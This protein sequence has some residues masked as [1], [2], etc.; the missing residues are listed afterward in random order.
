M[1]AAEITVTAT[2]TKT[3]TATADPTNPKTGD[4]FSLILWS[5]MAM[6]SLLC[7]AAMVLGKK[8]HG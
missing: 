4:E 1:P 6:T 2:F 5:G 3:N 8:K 7:M